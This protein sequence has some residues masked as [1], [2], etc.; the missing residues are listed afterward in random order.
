MITEVFFDVETKKLFSEIDKFD[1]ADLGVSIVSLYRRILDE[2]YI[3]KEGK[4]MSFWEADFQKLWPIFQEANRIIGFNSINFDVP[5]LEPYTNFPIKK[6]PHF[7]IM[8]KVKDVF[9]RRISLDSISKE[10]LGREKSDIGVNAVLYWQTGGKEN[11]KKLQRYCD[12]DVIITKELYDFVLK[13]GYLH[14]KDKWNTQRRVD[15]DFS[16]PKEKS[17]KQIGLF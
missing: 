2:N 17:Q 14:F 6:L 5:A 10:T 16:Y 8:A 4:L 15:L 12:D 3:E 11:L 7:D 9:G 1:P 13:N